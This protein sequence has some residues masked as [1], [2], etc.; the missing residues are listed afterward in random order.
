M[1]D[2]PRMRSPL[3]WRAM[4]VL[5]TVVGDVSMVMG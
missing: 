1:L 4:W 2:V 5:D 3:V